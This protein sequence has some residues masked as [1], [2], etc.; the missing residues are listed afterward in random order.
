MK[1]IFAIIAMLFLLAGNVWAADL[2]I[3][4][5]EEMVGSN[6]ATKAD[7]LNRLS[8][9]EHNTDGTHKS[10]MTLPVGTTVQT[11]H[12][13]T[14][15]IG[16]TATVIPF[17]DTIPQNTE[18]AE[19]LTATITP[20]SATNVLIIDV[21]ISIVTLNGY[22]TVTGALFQDTAASA[23]SA[24]WLYVPA[25]NTGYPMI[26]SYKMTAG[27][28]SATTF[29]LRVGPSTGTAYWLSNTA[30]RYLGGACMVSIKITEVQ[31]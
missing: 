18:G 3:K 4:A 24:S 9:V 14:A 11:I 29:K 22:G 7:T 12:N 13:S 31:A 27:T 1:K 16:S 2:T 6:H 23:L 5:T 19:V 28:T 26:F 20:T 8:L 17:D 15:T 30:G 21:Y 25:A 10:T